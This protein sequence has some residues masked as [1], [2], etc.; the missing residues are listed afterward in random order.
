MFSFQDITLKIHHFSSVC[1]VQLTRNGSCK[2]CMHDYVLSTKFNTTSCI[3]SLLVS[4]KRVYMENNKFRESTVYIGLCNRVVGSVTATS[5][6][7]MTEML[8]LL[9]V[10]N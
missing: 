1:N 5:E 2:T 10:L 3:T 8:V 4:M 6:V 9:K 7:H